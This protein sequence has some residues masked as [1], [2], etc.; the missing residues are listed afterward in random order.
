ML[1]QTIER[2][3]SIQDMVYKWNMMRIEDH[4]IDARFN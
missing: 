3:F 2:L 4:C 1:N